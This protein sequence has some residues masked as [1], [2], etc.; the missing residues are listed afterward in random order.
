MQIALAHL[1]HRQVFVQDEDCDIKRLRQQ[2]VT[3]MD[4]DDPLNQVCAGQGLHFSL[5]FIQ[6]V[7]RNFLALLLAPH[8]LVNVSRVDEGEL[9]IRVQVFDISLALRFSQILIILKIL[10]LLIGEI[11]CNIVLLQFF[12]DEV[13][14]LEEGLD[15]LLP[16]AA[17]GLGILLLMLVRSSIFLVL[18]LDDEFFL[19][20]IA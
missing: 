6:V 18:K 7:W 12:I 3:S 17:T 13:R 11:D 1:F 15:D 5:H 19:S 8:M 10:H 2:V 9:S 14:N 4:V 20:L 16:A